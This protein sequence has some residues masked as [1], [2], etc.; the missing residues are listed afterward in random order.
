MAIIIGVDPGSICLGFGV[1]RSHPH[2]LEHLASG[3]IRLKQKLL[4]DRLLHLSKEIR[5]LL[6]RY[7]PQ[8]MVIEKVFLGKNVQSA[9][10]LGMVRGVCI[11]EARRNGVSVYEYSPRTVKKGVSGSGAANKEQVQRIVE[12]E[13]NVRDLDGLDASDALSLAIHHAHTDESLKKQTQFI[14]V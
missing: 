14:Q 10:K 3:T 4:A 7:L 11:C 6:I 5:E 8:S 9:F 1:L 12:Y 13:L 2:H